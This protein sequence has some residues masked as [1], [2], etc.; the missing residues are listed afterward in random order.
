MPGQ[1]ATRPSNRLLAAGTQVQFDELLRAGHTARHEIGHVLFTTGDAVDDFYFPLDGLISM[2]VDTLDGTTVEV[3]IVGS[4]GF[5]GVD[6]YLGSHLASCNAV[7]QVAGEIVRI[8][9]ESFLAAVRDSDPV[10]SAT[11]LFLRM[12]LVETAQSAACNQLHS[13]EQRTARWLS[14]AADQ[15]HT[16]DLR[17]THE[18]LAQMLAVRRSSVTSVVGIFA[19]A[20]LIENHRGLITIADREGLRGFSCECYEVV[21]QAAL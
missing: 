3:A 19:R 14:H 8:P 9:A 20:A 11:E 15:A 1:L 18:F 5:V 16:T 13:V 6:R 21:R 17:L 12:L 10:R 4:A 7:V 2:T